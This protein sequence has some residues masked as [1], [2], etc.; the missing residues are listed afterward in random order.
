MWLLVAQRRRARGVV[1]SC[2]KSIVCSPWLVA[3]CVVRQACHSCQT[4][5]DIGRHA[6]N[7]L[8]PWRGDEEGRRWRAR[9]A[10][11][12]MVVGM[13]GRMLVSVGVDDDVCGGLLSMRLVLLVLLV[14]R[15][16]E[17]AG[18][19]S[20][21]NCCKIVWNSGGGVVVLGG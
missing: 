9:K 5:V 7:Q 15:R 1:M 11:E 6:S 8:E 17:E 10:G 20:V 3:K 2:W 18:L 13:V 14:T 19:R 16:S 12:G 21:I 4:V